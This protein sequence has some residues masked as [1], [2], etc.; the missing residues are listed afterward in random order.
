[1][2]NLGPDPATRVIITDTLPEGVEFVSVYAVGPSNMVCPISNDNQVICELTSPL[3]FNQMM[4]IFIEVR[5]TTEA[6]GGWT[7]QVDV[8]S[9]VDDPNVANNRSTFT[10]NPRPLTI[11]Y[12]EMATLD[13][14][15][16]HR[17]FCPSGYIWDTGAERIF[18]SSG[19]PTIRVDRPGSAGIDITN[20]SPAGSTNVVTVEVTGS[21]IRQQL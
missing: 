21:C 14:D 11:P 7:N 6:F 9:D 15:E 19:D 4:D 10:T 17:F 12:S 18:V 13:P 1:V 16:T 20:T 8:R 3:G 5:A 2:T